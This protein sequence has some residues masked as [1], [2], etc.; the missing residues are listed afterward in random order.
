LSRCCCV[1][2]GRFAEN[3]SRCGDGLTDV[4][5]R[6][7]RHLLVELLHLGYQHADAAVRRGCAYRGGVARSVYAGT[8]TEETEQPNSRVSTP[9]FD[10]RASIGTASATVL[11]R[12]ES[13]APRARFRPSV[14][15]GRA[16]SGRAGEVS[17]DPRLIGFSGL[18]SSLRGP[19]SAWNRA[20]QILNGQVLV[21][22]MQA[23]S[24][25][26]TVQPTLLAGPHTGVRRAAF[27]ATGCRSGNRRPGGPSLGGQEGS[28]RLP[29]YAAGGACLIGWRWRIGKVRK[30][31]PLAEVSSRSRGAQPRPISR[32]YED[33][34]K[35]NT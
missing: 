4:D 27:L 31:A 10:D 15:R 28:P 20:K 25:S 35:A 5:R 34:P 19:D 6:S 23:L 22:V 8:V 13:T 11:L 18:V 14:G 21:V 26:V 16:C 7:H 33:R 2:A 9:S 12:A 3:R 32:D 17:A 29:H 24:A 30:D 1:N